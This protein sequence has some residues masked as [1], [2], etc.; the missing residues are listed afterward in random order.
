MSNSDESVTSKITSFF[1]GIFKSD[2]S[3]ELNKA[4][5]NLN[6]VKSECEK[7]I[8]DAESE[9]KKISSST[10]A[11]ATAPVGGKSRRKGSRKSK[12]KKNKKTR[13]S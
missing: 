8:R 11:T 13:R 10:L 2:P 9:V 6:K 5:E 3:K 1:T 12:G 7:K 4:T